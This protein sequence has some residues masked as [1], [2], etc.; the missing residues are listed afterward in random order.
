MADF[1]SREARSRVM[2]SI[3]STNTKLERLLA[4]MIHK[5]GLRYRKYAKDLPGKPD[6]VF[7][8]V[9]VAVFVNGDFWHG[10]Q[11]PKWE[12]KL[13]SK[14]W[15]GKIRGN[16]ARDRRNHAALRRMGWKVIRIW[17]HQL[18]RN[19][20]AAAI[21][22]IRIVKRRMKSLGSSTKSASRRTRSGVFRARRGR[23][24]RSGSV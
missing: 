12:H 18:K 17:E 10:W 6:F 2:A 1:M 8:S 4:T 16:R 23:S 11:L 15:K 9:K 19:P 14:Y 13:S 3:R 22:I 21:N 5:A 24:D 7:R 20:E